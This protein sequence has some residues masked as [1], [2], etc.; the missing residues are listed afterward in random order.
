VPPDYL[1]VADL[2]GMH[3]MLI[4]RYGGSP[5][6]RD[7]CIKCY[8]LKFAYNGLQLQE[9]GDFEAQNS[10]PPQSFVR[11]A[12]PHLIDEPPISCRYC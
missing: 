8:Y 9:V 12:K 2:L 11:N 10:L 5:G 6:A 7:P 3:T 1:T 4:Q